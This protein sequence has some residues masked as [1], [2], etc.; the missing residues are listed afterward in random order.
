MPK[1][2]VEKSVRINAPPEKVFAIVSDLGNWRPWNPWLITE[3]QAVVDVAPGGKKYTWSGKRTGAGEMRITKEQSPTSVDLDL[4]FLKPFKS[5]STVRFQIEPDAQG[6]R[7]SWTMDSSLPFFMF[8]MGKTLTNMIGM[9]Y[10]RGLNMLKDYAE[11]G[12]VPSKIE[13]RGESTYPGCKYVGISTECSLSELGPRMSAD[14]KKLQEWQRHAGV[15]PAGDAFSTYLK[16]DLARG[17]VKYTSGVPVDSVPE[18]LPGPLESGEIPKLK[19]Y[20]LDHVGPYRHLGNAWSTGMQMGRAKEFRTSKAF[21]PFEIYPS[22][23][24][25]TLPGTSDENTRTSIHF[26]VK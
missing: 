15:K 16:W 20:V 4:V 14:F 2:Q 24:D 18:N 19:T 6:C 13:E 21:T 5:T 8:F 22:M 12:S 7:V 25:G 10:E 26:A 3:P 1:L 11:T 17:R 9:D 23:A